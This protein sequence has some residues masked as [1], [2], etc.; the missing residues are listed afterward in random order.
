MMEYLSMIILGLGI[1]LIITS[2]VGVI[3]FPDFYTKLYPAGITDSLG[4]SLILIG[5]AMRS[6]FSIFTIKILLLICLL[7]VTGTTASYAL[8]RSAYYKDKKGK[9][10]V[11]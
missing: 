3:R 2:V 11:E 7:W 8:A 10:D 4:A 6:E 5:L 1:F 9:G